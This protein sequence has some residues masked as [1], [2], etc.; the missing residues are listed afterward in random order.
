MWG[1][2]GRDINTVQDAT[3]TG[4]IHMAFGGDTVSVINTDLATGSQTQTDMDPRGHIGPDV[5]M[6]S[7]GSAGHSDQHVPQQQHSP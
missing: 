4:D 3:Q 5:T 7:D 6:A 1:Q 2:L